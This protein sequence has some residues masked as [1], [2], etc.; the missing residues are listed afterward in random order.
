M[1][2]QRRARLNDMIRLFK[3]SGMGGERVSIYSMG[4]I[5]ASHGNGRGE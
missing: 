5:L 1:T 3:Q 4:A 2:E